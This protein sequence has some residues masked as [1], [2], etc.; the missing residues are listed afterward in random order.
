MF[1]SAKVCDLKITGNTARTGGM[2]VVQLP[3]A[4][5]ATVL[6][7]D[8]TSLSPLL[9]QRVSIGIIGPNARPVSDPN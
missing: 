5:H 6:L 8:S 1:K 7:Y 3:M 2:H 4:P 9:P